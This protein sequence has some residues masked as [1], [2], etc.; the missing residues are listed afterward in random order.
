[1]GHPACGLREGEL[2]CWGPLSSG[3]DAASDPITPTRIGTDSDWTAITTYLGSICG[4]RNAGELYCWGSDR[5]GQFPTATR[6]ADR[7]LTP[8]RIGTE[9][10]DTI[11]AGWEYFCGTR[12]G[13]LYCWGDNEGGKLGI[14]DSNTVAPAKVVAAP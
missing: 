8:F 12:E 4:L 10:W 6:P 13:T 2:Y 11:V 7:N 5:I 14:G 3:S 1:M 9:R